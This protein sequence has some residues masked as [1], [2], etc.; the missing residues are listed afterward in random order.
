VDGDQTHNGEA[1]DECPHTSPGVL[2]RGRPEALLVL[3]VFTIDGIV[4]EV[5]IGQDLGVE[6]EVAGLILAV[7]ALR[8]VHLALR[9]HDV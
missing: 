8:L 4:H 7:D 5:R 1:H 3:A 2:L 6:L 9:L